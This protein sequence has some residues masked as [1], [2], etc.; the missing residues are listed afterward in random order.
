MILD[1]LYNLHR[2]SAIH[3][4]FGKVCDYLGSVDLAGLPDGCYEID[5]TDIFM[6][7]GESRLRKEE[8]AAV[9]A[10]DRYIDIQILLRGR[11]S[12]GWIPRSEC[13]WPDGGLDEGK[14]VIFYRDKPTCIVE[15]RE[16]QM[17][18]FFPDDGHAPLIGEGAV[19]KCVVKV[20]V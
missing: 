15:L 7:I 12:Q 5:G 9:E 14:D 20:A 19:R 6:T 18:V 3:T 10:H 17:T 4:G 13:R 2:Y 16:G 1:N 11:E 8:D